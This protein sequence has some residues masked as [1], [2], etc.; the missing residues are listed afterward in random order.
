MKPESHEQARFLVDEEMMARIPAE[1]LN[2][3]KRHTQ[4]CA[5]CRNYYE[6]SGRIM[7]GLRSLSFETD[8]EM[9]TRVMEA[10]SRHRAP[11]RASRW[12]LVAAAL[13]VMASLPVLHYAR[14][15][16]RERADALFVESVDA[17]L[18]RTV[19][20]AM[21]PLTGGMR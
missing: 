8:P 13:F 12:L 21:E 10:I 11:G 6:L 3:L 17:R 14:E 7:S 9:T 20:V 19:P 2:W 1:D 18:S 5:A 4:E 16:R 15:T